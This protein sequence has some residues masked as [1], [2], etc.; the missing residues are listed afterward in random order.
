MYIVHC[1]FVR[2]IFSMFRRKGVCTNSRT[3]NIFSVC[4]RMGACTNSR[5]INIFSVCIGERVCTN[6]RTIN[7]SNQCSSKRA[8]QQKWSH[9][10]YYTFSFFLGTYIF[11]FFA[12]VSFKSKIYCHLYLPNVY[13]SILLERK[14]TNVSHNLSNWVSS[15]WPSACSTTWS[16]LL[17]IFLKCSVW[18]FRIF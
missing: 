1:I 10:I 4:R 12:L 5:T 17:K 3:I 6:S 15:V 2:N 8:H 13:F 14:N 18:N 9:Q 16:A 7:P 11:L